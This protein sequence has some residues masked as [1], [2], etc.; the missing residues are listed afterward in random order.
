MPRTLGRFLASTFVVAGSFCT[1]LTTAA[2]DPVL[3]SFARQPLNGTYY[4]EGANAGDLNKDGHPDV[5]YGPFW[6][7]GPKFTEAKEIYPAKPQNMN[8]YA[9]NFFNWVYDVNG[10]GWNDVVVVGFPGTPGLVY[11]NPK[12]DGFDKPWKKHAILPSVANESPQFV[13]VVG[14]EK[15]ELV[16]AFEKRVGFATINPENPFGPWEFHGVSDANAP[17]RFG[18]GLGVGDV[19]GDGKPD[20]LVAGGWYEK[21]ATDA[22]TKP[23]TFHAVKFTNAYGGADMFAYDVDGDGDSDVITS[24]A[25]H[26]FGL[27]WFEQVKGDGESTWKQHLIMGSQPGQNAFGLVFSELHSVALEDMDGDGLKDIITGK[28]YYSHHQQSPMWDAGAVVYW[29]KLTRTKD[30]VEWIPFKADGD[31]G[32]G[33]QVSI[34]DVNG[35]KLPDIVVGGMLGTTVLTQ[36]RKT[37]SEAD[38]KAALPKR[39]T[40]AAAKPA[41]RGT[42]PEFNIATGKIDGAIEGESLKVASVSGGKTIAQGMSGFKADQWSAAKQLFWSGGKPGD[43][44][45]LEFKAAA[46][47]TYDLSAVF[48]MARDYAIV[49]FDVDGDSLGEPLDLFNDPDVITTGVLKIGQTKLTAGTHRLGITIV[50]KNPAAAPAHMFG[51]DCL[52]LAAADDKK[53]SQTTPAA[54]PATKVDNLNFEQ[55]TLAGWKATGR[56]F[57]GQPIEGD[58]VAKRRTDMKSGHTG[59]YWIGGYEKLGDQAVGTLTS[60]PITVPQPWATMLVGGGE[61]EE[62]RVEIV[63]ADT[64]QVVFQ[65]SGQNDEEMRRVV[66]DLRPHVGKPILV[67][68]VDQHRGGW[69]HINFDDFRFHEQQPGPPAK[70]LVKLILDDYPHGGLSADA[71]AKTMTLPQGFTVTPFAAEPDVRQPIAMA[72]DDRGRVWIAEAY[73]YPRRAPEGKGRDQILI[74]EDTNGDGRHDKRTVF[75]EGLNLVSGMEVGFGGVWVGAAPYLLFIPD[76]NGDDKPDSEPQILLDGW[77]HQDTHETLNAFIWGPDGWLYGCHGVFTHSR[78]GKPGTPDE[79]RQLI[80]AGIWRY[81]PTRHTFEVF[82]HGTS[83]PWGVDFND[84]GEAFATACVIPHLYHI[85]PG[86]RYERQAGPHFNTY[87]YNDIKTIADHRHYL[88]ATPH[89]GNS[90][91][92]AAGGGHAH[93]G[94]MIYLGGAWPDRYRNQLFMNNIHGQRLNMDTLAEKGSGY[95]GGHGPDFLLTGDKASQILNLRY[96]PDGQAFMIDWYDMQACHLNDPSRHDRSNGRIYK[97]S[98]GESKPVTVDLKQKS[99]LELAELMLSPNDWY[100]RHAR[101]VLQERATTNPISADAVAKLTSIATTHADDTRRLRGAWALHVIGGLTP[102]LRQKLLTDASP[103]VRG[104]S[105]R[106][107]VDQPQPAGVPTQFAALAKSDPSPVVRLALAS[108]AQ[109]LPVEQRWTLLESLVAHAED[110]NDHNLPLMDW[111]AAEPLAAADTERALAFA[112]RA[113][114]SIPLIREYMLRRIGSLDQAASLAA[115]VRGL[116]KTTDAS[117]QVTF[118][119]AIQAALK[120]QRTVAAPAEWAAVSQSLLNSRDQAVQQAA[121]GLGVKFGDKAAFGAFRAIV[122]KTDAAPADRR[123]ALDD[124]LAAKDPELVPILYR[125]LADKALRDLAIRGL[126]QYQDGETPPRLLELYGQLGTV[127]DKRAVLGT[128]ASRGEYGV[129]LLKAVE[130]R[131]IPGTDLTAD[132]VRQLQ[133]LKHDEVNRLLNDVWGSARETAADKVQLIASLKA[134]VADTNQP[135]P[136]VS[137]GRAIFHKT[138]QKCHVLYGVGDKIGPDLT[139][140]NR[141]DLDYLLSNIVDPSAVMAKE[142]QPTIIA[143]TDG[144]VVS[145]LVRSE[146]AKSVTVQTADALVTLPKMEIDERTVSTKSM[147]PDDQLKLFGEH[148]TRSLIAYLRGRQQTAMLAMATNAPTM[149]NGKSL[150]GWTGDSTLWSVEDGELVGRTNGLKRNEWIVSDLTAEDFR[151]TVQVKLVGN[152]GNSGIQFRSRTVGNGEVAGYQA[153]IG[154]GW[155]GKLYEEHGR[156]LLWDKSGEAHVRKGEWNEYRIEARGPKLQTWINGEPCVDLTDPDGAKRGIF[157]L[158]LHSGGK[159]EV[160]YRNFELTILDAE[161][162]AKTAATGAQ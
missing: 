148:E 51:L 138:C 120:G 151:L 122:A 149:F 93:A 72:L 55:G 86:A 119:K 127:E 91:S 99:D 76:K 81:H 11:E 161:G 3:L 27:S 132:L 57:E 103:H 109:R 69:G 107:A 150:A 142:Y 29:F 63:R 111:Y 94:A 73:E 90:K 12:V 100:V 128:L 82:A 42:K 146:D 15:P 135:A 9:D 118:L 133:Y 87:T 39:Y 56:A 35:D 79:Q 30:G 36:S 105:V 78:V 125:S 156:A 10:D 98:Y 43:K 67:R 92:D 84:H 143:T 140:S 126:A 16:C 157:A 65:A 134:L 104:W 7:A 46:D 158:Q 113:G 47:G 106:L 155:W 59:K 5:V 45:E 53:V 48:T 144:R 95:V 64:Q 31:A 49:K 162:T 159:T 54:A 74:F 123:A 52:V 18:H 20:I 22:L 160:R 68:L 62:T 28:T 89:G 60:A 4:S 1:G 80:N 75:A 24:L 137:L 97:I 14:D 145:G 129:A 38:W 116:G 37:V 147:M 40:A 70:S 141:N 19:S 114:E 83:N 136:D 139:G 121:L 25:A 32:I 61:H 154:A 33:R 71:A 88:G 152:A 44:L 85:I 131:K 102:E 130:Q 26:D 66:V 13:N 115:L 50:G 17:D 153:D 108:A 58:T 23:W 6:Y 2:A 101:R 34:V 41:I 96:G 110:A 77:G 112:L 8:G 124:L 21:P 117:L